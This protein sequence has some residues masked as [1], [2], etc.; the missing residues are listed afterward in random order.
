[1]TLHGVEQAEQLRDPL[2]RVGPESLWDGYWSWAGWPP[3]CVGKW[4]SRHSAAAR[5]SPPPTHRPSPQA[6]RFLRRSRA[7]TRPQLVWLIGS[8]GALYNGVTPLTMTWEPVGL[9][10]DARRQPH[11]CC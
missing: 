6:P 9:P 8:R 3:R 2:Q 10:G 4:G 11:R 7:A 1:M 5:V